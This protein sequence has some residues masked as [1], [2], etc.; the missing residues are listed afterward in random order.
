M[1]ASSVRPTRRPAVRLL[2]VAAIAMSATGCKRFI[3]SSAMDTTTDV[4]YRAKPSMQQ[5]S[6]VELARAALPG[7]IKTIEGFHVANPDNEILTGMLAEA[8]CQYATGFIQDEWEIAMWQ[9]RT[10][11]AA[12]LRE[13]ATGLFLRCMNYG[14]EL[15]GSSWET[16]IYGD[17]AAVQRLVARAGSGSL[18]G[19]FWTALGLASA[20]NMNRDDIAMVTHLAKARMMLER[21]IAIDSDYQ[22]GLAHMALGMIYS[23]QGAALGGQPDK[24]KQHFEAAIAATKGKFLLT[25]VMYA[26]TYAVIVQDQKLFR[27]LLVKVLKES[28]AIWPDQRLANELAHLRAKRY[29]KQEKEWF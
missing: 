23:A 12:E 25:R 17:L 26:R 24:S 15:L 7:A 14:L 21:V 5:E 18:E 9:G 19:M 22:H 2:A 16:A 8:Y 11:D 29:L 1:R 4:L 20:I 27:D 28:P 10:D 13:R 6:D 3:L